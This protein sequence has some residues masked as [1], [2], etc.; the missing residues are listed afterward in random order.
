MEDLRKQANDLLSFYG[1]M[2]SRLTQVGVDDP[3]ALVVL[4]N[5]LQRGLQS[6]DGDELEPAIQEVDRLIEALGRMQADLQILRELKQRVDRPDRGEP[7]EDLAKNNGEQVEASAQPKRR[8]PV[9]VQD[10]RQ[11]QKGSGRPYVVVQ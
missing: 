10:R 8:K 6:I 2:Q 3:A 7:G 1:K 4:F 5:Q 9:E 11:R